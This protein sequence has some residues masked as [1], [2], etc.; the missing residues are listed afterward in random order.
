MF[1]NKYEIQQKKNKCYI[2]FG[3]TMA[4]LILLHTFIDTF[5]FFL[6]RKKAIEMRGLS[7][8]EG[9]AKENSSLSDTKLKNG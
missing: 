3:A 8:Q 9:K 7:I 5:I 2:S 6:I 4:G 1:C